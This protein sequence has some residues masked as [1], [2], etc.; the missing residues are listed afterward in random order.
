MAGAV[1]L[2]SKNTL[3][4]GRSPI[5]LG[6]ALHLDASRAVS[7]DG[8]VNL[9]DYLNSSRIFTPVP[10]QH[11]NAGFVPSS[12]VI[13]TVDG[14]EELSFPKGAGLAAAYDAL[15]GAA[16]ATIYLVLRATLSGAD[17][18]GVIFRW[19]AK[20]TGV[21]STDQGFLLRKYNTASAIQWLID[22]GADSSSMSQVFS[23]TDY[24]VACIGWSLAENI[25][26]FN[27]NGVE[28]ANTMPATSPVGGG[29]MS[30]GYSPDYATQQCAMGLRTVLGYATYH[31]VVTRTAM[32][33]KLM[34]DNSVS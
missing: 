29:L 24:I 3:V 1:I 4:T 9:P 23:R 10:G 28:V 11:G 5:A 27:V 6:D 21:G 34:T 19:M 25:S 31:D 2:K 14:F 8:V 32:I 18:N 26:F 15:S 13:Q 30:F 22:W 33:Q 7:V 12:P 16:G 17:A 20:Y